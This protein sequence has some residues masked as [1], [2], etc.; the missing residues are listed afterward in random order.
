MLFLPNSYDDYIRSLSSNQRSNIGKAVRRFEK[1]YALSLE[2]C[3]DVNQL[4]N[5]FWLFKQMHD[6]QWNEQGKR[7]HF[8]S[9][10][11]AAEFNVALVRCLGKLGRVRL[12]RI[13]ADDQVVARMYAFVFGDCSH[14]ILAARETGEVSDRL[15]LGSLTT[16]KVIEKEISQG[17]RRVDAGLGHYEYKL[18]YRGQECAVHSLLIV[19]NHPI[20]WCRTRVYVLA[21]KMLDKM[22][23]DLIYRR[24]ALAWSFL[25]RPLW[26]IWIRS[27]I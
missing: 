14:W 11:L 13:M 27:Q 20:S 22:Y 1:E 18:R 4:E 24:L 9:W 19:R 10:P 17:V 23:H 15:S 5:E 7:G 12:F 26:G 16:V 6:R 21:S 3:E 2:S 8:G 25:R